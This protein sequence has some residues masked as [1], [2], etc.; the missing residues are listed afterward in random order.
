MKWR[1]KDRKIFHSSAKLIASDSNIVEAFTSVH[2]N[3]MTKIKSYASEECI[4][5]D[6]ITKHGI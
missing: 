4:V 2:Q 5:L 1:K 6:I 3:I